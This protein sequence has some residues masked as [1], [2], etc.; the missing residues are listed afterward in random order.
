MIS[1]WLFARDY[2][3]MAPFDVFKRAR[4]LREQAE[5]TRESTQVPEQ[6]HELL[7]AAGQACALLA[8]AAFDL[9]SLDGAKRLARSAA[10]YG[11]TARLAPLR[12]I[13][14]LTAQHEGIQQ[15]RTRRRREDE[16][17]A[18][19][20]HLEPTPARIR[21]VPPQEGDL[22]R[23]TPTATRDRDGNLL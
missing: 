3:S 14:R 22:P 9:G 5:A 21:A 16:A 20:T 18:V 10:L 4:E 13:S 8:T 7:I 6:Q 19:V 23:G 12:A 17:L 2:S 1:S 11:E 15:L